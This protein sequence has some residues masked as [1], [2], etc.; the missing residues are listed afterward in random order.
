MCDKALK[1]RY[2]TVQVK[3][4]PINGIKIGDGRCQGVRLRLNAFTRN[5]A[6]LVHTPFLCYYGDAKEQENELIAVD[7]LGSV[8]K[9]WSRFIPCTD[10]NEVFV[11][12]VALNILGWPDT[13]YVQVMICEEAD[14]E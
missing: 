2:I 12:F 13:A 7:T 6:V 14:A 4:T 3:N 11:R 1:T 10:L 8:N 5:T 9:D